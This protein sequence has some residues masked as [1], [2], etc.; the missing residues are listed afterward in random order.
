MPFDLSIAEGSTFVTGKY[1]RGF[2]GIANMPA[3]V[4]AG[5]SSVTLECWMRT[6]DTG[7]GI[8]CIIGGNNNPL[9]G[10]ENGKAYAAIAIPGYL[11]ITSTTVVNDGNWHHL[12]LTVDTVAGSKLWVD[13]VVAGST[14]STC[15][16]NDSNLAVGVQWGVGRVY[17]GDMDDV[18]VTAGIKYT[19][20]FTPGPV[21]N[22]Q[23]GLLA[24][25]HFSDNG[26]D[27]KGIVDPVEPAATAYTFTGPTSGTVGFASGNF[28]VAANGILAGSVTVTPSASNGTFTPSSVTLTESARSAT[29]THTAASA[30]AR[31]ITTTNNGSLTNPAG[32]SFNAQAADTTAPT[33]VSAVVNDARPNII[34]VTMSEALANSVP[35]PSALTPS[36]GRTVT[37]V[38]APTGATF[39]V[40]INTPYKFG[41]V[42]T[43]AYTAPGTNPRLQ[44][45][46][47]APSP[48][49]TATFAAQ[50][51][52]NNVASVP[53][54]IA[55]VLNDISKGLW[56][57]LTGADL[58]PMINEATPNQS[59]YISTTGSEPCELA[60][61]PVP[62]PGTS[63]NQVVSVVVEMEAGGRLAVNLKQGSTLIASRTFEYVQAG[64][65]TVEARLTSSECDAITN[66]SDL[67]IELKPN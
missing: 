10:V 21:L 58:A 6:T 54:G 52:T 29:F 63:S 44:D 28:T 19:A 11:S 66:Y 49:V 16:I 55:R 57:A 50:P 48:N 40:T 18:A 67:R 62:D 43:L 51:V 41:D 15:V 35:P 53:A 20:S 31:T 3:G 39:P 33:F 8:G 4:I 9:L 26:I 12:A 65:S 32:I 34:L 5:Q 45:A 23:S 59:T 17:V 1:G 56:Q 14:A 61:A 38:G 30:G 60:L 24:V 22:N 36:L 47:T 64:F 25:W 7:T 2:N 37:A 42:V 27:S 13:G 46:S